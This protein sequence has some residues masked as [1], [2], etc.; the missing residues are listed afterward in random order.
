[1]K[2]AMPQK[3]NKDFLLNFTASSKITEQERK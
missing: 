3:S 2:L 1:M